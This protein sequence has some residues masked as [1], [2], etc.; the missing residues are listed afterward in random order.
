MLIAKLVSASKTQD[1]IRLLVVFVTKYRPP[2]TAPAI[3]ILETEKGSKY[4]FTVLELDVSKIKKK[5][6]EFKHSRKNEFFMSE[7][8][9]E[10]NGEII[11][12]KNNKTNKKK[13]E[14]KSNT[15]KTTKR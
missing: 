14:D 9:I 8:Q 5:E 11:K 2:V 7:E 15:D 12:I 4:S 1:S 10:R 6:K 13:D 3:N